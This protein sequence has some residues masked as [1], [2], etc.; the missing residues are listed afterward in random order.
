MSNESREDLVRQVG[1]AIRTHQNAVDQLDEAAVAYLGI[2]RTDARCLDILGFAGRMTAG[3]LAG[4]SGLSTGAITT[5]LDRLEGKGYVRRIRDEVDR[6]K[7]LVE[8]T[9]E[10]E[11]RTW[12]VY[13]RVVES[14][15]EL[16]SRYTDEELV[17][18]RDFMILGRDFLTGYAAEVRSMASAARP[19]LARDHP[20]SDQI[21]R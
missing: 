18:I 11:A 13:R 1:E 10:G 15:R 3:D 12:D 21:V 17:M 19:I 2:N 5:V 4:R 6:R 9:E 7:V 20:S 16:L 8:I 14:G